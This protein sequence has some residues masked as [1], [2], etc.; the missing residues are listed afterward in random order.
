[1]KS[2]TTAIVACAALARHKAIEQHVVGREGVGLARRQHGIARVWSRA[3]TIAI[4][5]PYL[6]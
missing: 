5:S 1:M 4:P 2:P 3:D 6:S